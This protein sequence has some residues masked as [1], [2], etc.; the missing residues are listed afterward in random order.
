FYN[1]TVLDNKNVP[2]FPTPTIG[3]LGI[4]DNADD[5]MTLDFKEEGDLIYLIGNPCN[6]FG[7]SEY[8]RRVHN[9]EQSPVPH[10]DLEE[11]FKLQAVIK[12][13]I[14]K[15]AVQSVHDVA[16]GGLFTNLVESGMVN[17]MGFE[18]NCGTPTRKDAFL[19]G[20]SQSRVVVSVSRVNQEAFEN[21]ISNEGAAS[22][23]LGKV[24][25]ENI[26]IDN[27]DYGKI[28]DWKS[29]FDNTLEQYLED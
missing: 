25:G 17:G 27:E 1:H 26:V 9:V 23:L 22:M 10:F 16:D 19:F 12:T 14:Q 5:Y 11:E 28:A 20:E 15:K 7:S 21:L 8:L 29:V 4:L 3:M 18:V 2:V 13:L 6:D 24:M